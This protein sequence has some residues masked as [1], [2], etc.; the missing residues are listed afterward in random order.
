MIFLKTFI[1]FEKLDMLKNKTISDFQYVIDFFNEF[2][3]QKN[4]KNIPVYI[5]SE[6]DWPDGKPKQ[7]ENDGKGGIRIHEDQVDNDNI[8][9]W[10]VHEVGHVLDL[11]GER[12][13]FIV[14][15]EV[16][17]TYPN[18]DNEQTPM[19]YHFHYLINKGL[20]EN[21]IINLLKQDYSNVKGGGSLWKPEKNT[22]FRAYYKKIN[23]F[24]IKNKEKHYG[25]FKRF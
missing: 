18:V 1:Q 10:L 13:P 22:F 21:E 2:Y 6:D 11:N 15:K 8:I 4:I 17:S 25:V 20:S 24:S 23:N 14:D 16:L 19:Y 9:G 3:P 7:T 12:K 5:I